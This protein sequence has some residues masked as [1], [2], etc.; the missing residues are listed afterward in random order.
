MLINKEMI[1]EAMAAQ[2]VRYLEASFVCDAMLPF[3]GDDWTDP[4]F[5]WSLDRCNNG[6]PLETLLLLNNWYNQTPPIGGLEQNRR[7]VQDCYNRVIS[8]RPM[9]RQDD[10]TFWNLFEPSGWSRRAI[11]DGRCLVVNMAPGIWRS[12]KTTGSLTRQ[13][14]TEALVVLW[15]PMIRL[16]QP[17]RIYFCGAWARRLSTLW[18]RDFPN[19]TIRIACHPC[20]WTR[21]WNNG[22]GPEFLD[23][24]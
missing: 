15:L 1:R 17:R 20:A 3:D 11:D 10:P 13:I 14:Y 4:L 5:D 23:Q 6:E 24:E 8:N 21:R 12:D 19:S 22:D 16:Y 18:Q 7:Y 2:L 9:M